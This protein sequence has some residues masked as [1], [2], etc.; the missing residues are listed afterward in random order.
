[1]ILL[2]NQRGDTLVEVLFAGAILGVML[3]G[4]FALANQTYSLGLQARERTEATALLQREVER[5]V[6]LRNTEEKRISAL[7][8][9]DSIILFD[10]PTAVS[11]A[12]RTVFNDLPSE[13]CFSGSVSP[14]QY[15]PGKCS[16]GLYRIWTTVNTLGA[17]KLEITVNVDWNSASSSAKNLSDTELILTDRRIQPKLCGQGNSACY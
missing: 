10:P 12:E 13:V 16:N 14:A 2:N 6:D 8:N 9:G 15:T 1:M 5:I 17:D 4:A 3:V 11:P 7:P